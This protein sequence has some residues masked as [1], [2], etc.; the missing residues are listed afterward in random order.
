MKAYEYARLG[1]ENLA[2]VERPVPV[3]APHEVVVKIHAVSLNYRD[4]L[5]RLGT[6][7]S[8]TPSPGRSLL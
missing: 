1:L 4:L 3:P 6:L 7:Q 2:M 5:P 8:A